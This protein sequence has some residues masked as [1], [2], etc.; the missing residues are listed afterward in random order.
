MASEEGTFSHTL[1]LVL[2]AEVREDDDVD[3]ELF[4]VVA[5]AAIDVDKVHASLRCLLMERQD[6]VNGDQWEVLAVSERA[7]TEAAL[8]LR[9]FNFE[10]FSYPEELRVRESS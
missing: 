10:P 2:E 7:L 8:A 3:V 5:Q 9:G 4:K 1:A 6:S